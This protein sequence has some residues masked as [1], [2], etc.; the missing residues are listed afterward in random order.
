MW[1]I[2][3][4]KRIPDWSD[5]RRDSEKPFPFRKQLW[6]LRSADFGRKAFMAITVA[7]LL[8]R[9][10]GLGMVKDYLIRDYTGDRWRMAWGTKII[11]SIV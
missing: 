7:V 1:D 6:I 3:R 9:H 5:Q 10:T 4:G 11:V 8:L 2:L